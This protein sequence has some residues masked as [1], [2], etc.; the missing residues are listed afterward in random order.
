[1]TP[2]YYIHRSDFCGPFVKQTDALGRILFFGSKKAAE[3]AKAELEKYADAWTEFV[4]KG[5]K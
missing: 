3:D 1:M 4:V 5:E 2:T